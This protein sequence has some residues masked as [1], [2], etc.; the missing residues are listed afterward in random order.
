MFGNVLTRWGEV[1]DDRA[2]L[3]ELAGQFAIF[4]DLLQAEGGL[5][6]H[7]HGTVLTQEDDVFWGRGNGWVTA[8]GFDHLRVRR[9]RGEAAPAVLAAVRRQVDAVLPLQDPDNGLWW[10]V[11]NRP[12]E[13]YLETSAAALFAF[14]LARGWRYGWLD[15]EVL[16][17]VHRAV[18][19]VTSRVVRDEEGAAVVTGT[20]GPTNPGTFR[21]Y[22]GVETADDLPY[23][24]GAVLLALVETSGLP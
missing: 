2:A 22:S 3:D 9:N 11:L 14:G 23:G 12:G 19:G 20:S 17:A 21:Y 13:S 4:A 18:A 15:D 16:P 6:K 24:V 7:A 10:T 8:S 5:L 1:A